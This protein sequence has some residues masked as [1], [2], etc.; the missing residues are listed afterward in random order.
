METREYPLRLKKKK[1]SYVAFLNGISKG[2][3]SNL[4]YK[5]SFNALMNADEERLIIPLGKKTWFPL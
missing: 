4:C 1:S 2:E 3:K 5:L